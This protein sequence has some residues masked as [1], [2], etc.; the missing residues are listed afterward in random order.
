MERVY[1]YESSRLCLLLGIWNTFAVQRT[2]TR[3]GSDAA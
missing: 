1:F 3:T 2:S